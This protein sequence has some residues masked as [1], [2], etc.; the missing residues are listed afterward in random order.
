MSPEKAEKERT[1]DPTHQRHHT[2]VDM[3][4]EEEVITPTWNWITHNS[5][6]HVR[7]WCSGPA[8]LNFCRQQFFQEYVY[9]GPNDAMQKWIGAK[10]LKRAPKVEFYLLADDDIACVADADGKPRAIY[11]WGQSQAFTQ[12][13]YPMPPFLRAIA[14]RIEREFGEKVN[15]CIIIWY[16]H[17]TKQHAPPHK[18]KAEGVPGVKKN[19]PLDMARDAS[20][21]VLS[22]GF[23]RTFT[24][25]RTHERT[26]SK[27]N[28]ADVVWERAL[29]SGSLLKISAADNRELF[30]AVHKQAKAGERFS[31]IFRTI[32]TFAPVDAAVANECNGEVHRFCPG[33]QNPQGN[34][35]TR[36]NKRPRT[37]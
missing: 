9:T 14:Q 5:S 11:R 13:G 17:G 18:D 32:K 24:L 2:T 35:T 37:E 30:H 12:A 28:S 16:A 26:R 7:P 6:V 36:K 29:E 33:T 20:F 10:T 23:P 15:H 22:A 27:L 31:V 8:L 19:V 1:L 21:F 34:E 4:V 25:Q 3:E